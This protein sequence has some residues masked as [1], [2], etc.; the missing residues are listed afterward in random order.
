MQSHRNRPKKT[1]KS[2]NT[3]QRTFLIGQLDVPK[4][5]DLR[6]VVGCGGESVILKDASDPEKKVR[7]AYIKN[8]PSEMI[9][10]ELKHSRII[11]Y[12]ESQYQCIRDEVFHVTRK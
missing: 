3:S 8:R 6:N 1:Y 9:A 5:L 2:F 10:N 11:K 4:D 12:D 7:K